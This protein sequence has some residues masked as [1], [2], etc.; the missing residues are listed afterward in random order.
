MDILYANNKFLLVNVCPVSSFIYYAHLL[1]MFG[2][3][4]NRNLITSLIATCV[5][6]VHD[7]IKFPSTVF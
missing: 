4:D 7:R 6:I 2:V 3:L 5:N 1:Y